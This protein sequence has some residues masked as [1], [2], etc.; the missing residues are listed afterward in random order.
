MWGEQSSP[1]KLFNDFPLLLI[2]WYH[3]YVY[4]ILF[5]L[6]G[7]ISEFAFLFQEFIF[8]I[9]TTVSCYFSIININ[10]IIVTLLYILS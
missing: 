6:W 5:V 9:G 8:L 10:G 1:N 3:F 4:Q 2:C 7:L